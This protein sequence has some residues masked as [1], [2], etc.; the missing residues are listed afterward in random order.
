[1]HDIYAKPH[2]FTAELTPTK[3]GH[4]NFV[5]TLVRLKDST[6]IPF[7]YKKNICAIAIFTL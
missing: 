5:L 6:C 1:M 2:F 3:I 7:L 4:M